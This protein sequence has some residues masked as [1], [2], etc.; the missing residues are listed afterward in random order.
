MTYCKR[1]L[2]LTGCWLIGAAAGPSLRAQ[3]SIV[4]TSN[5]WTILYL[6]YFNSSRY[7]ADY[8]FR[9]AVTING[10]T[11]RRLYRDGFGSAGFEP[12]SHYLR[13]DG[14]DRYYVYDE[15]QQAEYLHYDFSLA[16]GDTFDLTE[17]LYAPEVFGPAT[18]VVEYTDTV[19]YADG[20]PRRRLGLR[21][22]AHSDDGG[23]VATWIEGRGSEHG[24]VYVPDGYVGFYEAEW[25]TCSFVTNGTTLYEP[26]VL[27]EDCE[28]SSVRTTTALPFRL[29]P[30]PAQ[31]ELSFDTELAIERVQLIDYGGRVVLDRSHPTQIDVQHLPPGTYAV[32]VQTTNGETAQHLFVKQ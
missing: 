26:S 19:V 31:Q 12:T 24:P 3:V 25:L 30:N 10:N 4:D 13:A 27:L 20:V 14:P 7:L 21:E 29:Y 1:L 22:V 6:E 5:V 9:E 16:V 28:P 8:E 15:E 23:V 2:L 18:L 11:Y 32:R 17:Q